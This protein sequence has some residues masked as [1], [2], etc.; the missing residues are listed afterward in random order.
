MNSFQ[1]HWNYQVNIYIWAWS[2]I[3]IQSLIKNKQYL[4]EIAIAP[5]LVKI[6]KI[7]KEVAQKMY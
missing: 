2:I 5:K 1:L 4:K 3:M 6:L 7:G